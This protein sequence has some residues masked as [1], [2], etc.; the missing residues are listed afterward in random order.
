[1]GRLAAG[2]L[3]AGLAV[4][5][6]LA[7]ATAAAVAMSGDGRERWIVVRDTAGDELARAALPVSGEFSLR[8][9]NSIYHS[10]AEEHYRVAGS[11]LRLVGL[12]ADELAV[13]EEYS[14]TVGGVRDR[15]GARLTWS[16][17][18][19]RPSIELPLRVQATPLGERTLLTAEGEVELWRLVEGRDDTLVILSV[20]EGR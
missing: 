13:L 20:E 11:E 2:R 4:V 19:E 15:P 17:D 12:A 3:A 7:T 18:V 8:Y 10:L 1:M 9:R 5:V 14:T 6:L 16:V